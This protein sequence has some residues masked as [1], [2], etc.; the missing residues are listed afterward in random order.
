MKKGILFLLLAASFSVEAQQSLKDLLYSGKLK[1]DSNTV[2]RKGDDLNAKIDT[3]TKKPETTEKVNPANVT[4]S[5]PVTEPPVNKV[6]ATSNANITAA[7]IGTTAVVP[8][9][10]AADTAM[11]TEPAPTET[12]AAAPPKSN[13]KLWK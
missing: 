11:K 8:G 2:I 3:S 4:T 1:S 10:I 6:A 9:I 7:N 5:A 12:V 13:T